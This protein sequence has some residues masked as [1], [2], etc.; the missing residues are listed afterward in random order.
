MSLRSVC[1]SVLAIAISLLTGCVTT[2]PLSKSISQ[3]GNSGLMYG[4]VVNVK[5]DSAAAAKEDCDSISSRKHRD[6]AQMSDE[7]FRFNMSLCSNLNGYDAVTINLFGQYGNFVKTGV[8]V[9]KAEKVQEGDIVRIY[10]NLSEARMHE[11]KGIAAR[12]SEK[13]AKNCDWVGSKVLNL[14]GVE[15][16]G[17]SY[18]SLPAFKS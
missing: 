3:M 5:E 13:Q 8:L 18:K 6:M 9:P 10:Q 17:W 12:A 7:A 15:C 4:Y 1:T 11:W 14:G 2:M 16:E